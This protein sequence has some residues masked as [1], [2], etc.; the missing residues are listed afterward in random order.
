MTSGQRCGNG[1]HEPR[2]SLRSHPSTTLLT[3][4]WVRLQ[5]ALR[6][7]R[8]EGLRAQDRAGGTLFERDGTLR[9]D[10][11]SVGTTCFDC[12]RNCYDQSFCHGSWLLKTQRCA[13]RS[14]QENVLPPN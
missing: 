11:S 6:E 4:R 12:A 14:A 7:R 10:R 2:T 9:R 1:R 13:S 8:G 3:A 5:R